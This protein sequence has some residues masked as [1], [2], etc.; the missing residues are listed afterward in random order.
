VLEYLISP[1]RVNGNKQLLEYRLTM[2]KI[3]ELN[4]RFDSKWSFDNRLAVFQVIAVDDGQPQRT[5]TATIDVIVDAFVDKSPAFTNISRTIIIPRSLPVNFYL[6]SVEA[7]SVD[8]AG[9]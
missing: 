9:K 5:G 7:K 6:C 4:L 8:P 2:R 3:T 1:T